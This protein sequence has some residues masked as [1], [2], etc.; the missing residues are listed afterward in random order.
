MLFGGIIQNVAIVGQASK[1]N[2]DLT[3][4]D[5]YII[6]EILD[7][8]FLTVYV[9]EEGLSEEEILEQVEEQVQE[10]IEQIM[11]QEL[12]PIST[13]NRTAATIFIARNG[14][15]QHCWVYLGWSGTLLV[16]NWRYKQI[17]ITDTSSLFPKTYDTFGNW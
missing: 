15:T 5:D 7:V 1:L 11:E 9:D 2:N 14:N 10:Q 8:E 3:F 13:R 12:D 6:D 16:S 4:Q 17:T